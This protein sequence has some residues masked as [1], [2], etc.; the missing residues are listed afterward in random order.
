MR[1][2]LL[3]I[4]AAL[5]LLPAALRAA[6]P[7]EAVTFSSVTPSGPTELVEAGTGLP[8]VAI[9]GWLSLPANDGPSPR[10]PVPA[11]VIA[12]GSGGI[13]DGRE[14][15]WAERLN[16]LGIASFV[17][18]SF[19]PRGIR[20][21]G[22]DQRQLSTMANV[23]DVLAAL[24]LLAADPRIDPA[25]IAVMGFS[26]GGQAALYAALE[27]FRKAIAGETLRFAAHV[28]LYP[29][30]S[31]PY[32]GDAGSG[33]RV[34]FALGGADDYT[35][36]EACLRYADWF[37]ARGAAVT[38]LVYAGAHHG[39]DT[40]DEPRFL[41]AVQSA[42]GCDGEFLLMPVVLR[43]RD[44]GEVL[45]GP[46]AIDAFLKG[47][48]QRGATFGGNP[49]ALEKAVADIGSFLRLVLRP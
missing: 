48:M 46:E 16:R 30:C 49:A 23:A 2:A 29:S 20:A 18:D 32:L 27:P 4:L 36:A 21:T 17:V 6:P 25:R 5:L 33:A 43:R 1:T 35:P 15:A 7:G 31:L 42:R 3:A 10:G 37:R 41:R 12:H 9:Q 34:L 22:T 24:R 14:R 44:T 8:P 19:G 38:T 39:F 11:V 13:R 45:Q 28:A 40:P 26:R 47:C